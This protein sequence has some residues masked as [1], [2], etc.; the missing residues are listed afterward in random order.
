MRLNNQLVVKGSLAIKSWKVNHGALIMIRGEESSRAYMISSTK[1]SSRGTWKHGWGIN[2]NAN[3]FSHVKIGNGGSLK[4]WGRFAC[5]SYWR[6]F[7]GTPE[8][9]YDELRIALR[10][11][12]KDRSCK[13]RPDSLTNLQIKTIYMHKFKDG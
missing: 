1:I 5:K 2:V 7:K 12:W 4:T 10:T 8:P 6:V 13:Q 3:E 11:W 9:R